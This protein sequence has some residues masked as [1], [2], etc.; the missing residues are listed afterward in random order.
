MAYNFI[1][2]NEKTRNYRLISQLLVIFNL[3]GFVFVTIQ[4][5]G[6]IAKNYAILFGLLITAVY[7]FFTVTEWVTKKSLPDFWHRSVFFFCSLAWFKQGHW[8][9]SIA[10]LLFIILDIIAHRKLIVIVAENNILIPYFPVKKAG[11]NELNNVI[12]KDGLLTIDFKN[13]RLFQQLILNSDRDV[14]EKD[15][16]DFC[17]TQ[18][19]KQ[20]PLP[21][22]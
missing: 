13:N 9:L 4:N 17:R 22:N 7:T 6:S 18:L 2:K 10:L 1:I 15:F 8:W 16:N 11:W 19:T 5:E 14:N 20:R 12:L 21:T 3:L